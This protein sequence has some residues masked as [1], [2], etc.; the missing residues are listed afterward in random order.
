MFLFLADKFAFFVKNILRHILHFIQYFELK[1]W[2]N[3]CTLLPICYIPIYEIQYK[4]FKIVCDKNCGIVECMNM[5]HNP[6]HFVT[7]N[8]EGP[9]LLYFTCMW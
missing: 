6:I 4:V 8:S 1:S 5:W 2:N 3:V 9:V 7:L